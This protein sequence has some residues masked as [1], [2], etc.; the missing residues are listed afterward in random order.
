MKE[1]I[2]Y[3][4]NLINNKHIEDIINILKDEY[5]AKVKYNNNLFIVSYDHIRTSFN[6]K[7]SIA[8][9]GTIFELDNN[10][11]F[12]GKIVCL[13]FYKFFNYGESN[14]Y[15]GDYNNIYSIYEKIDG[16]LIK[17]YYYNNKWCIGS[18]NMLN[19]YDCPID[20]KTL[21]DI[22]DIAIKKYNFNYN[23]LDKNKIYCLELV[24][25]ENRIVLKYNNYELYHLMTRC[26]IT[27]DEYED[28]IGIPKPINY[29]YKNLDDVILSLK[30]IE[31]K[32]GYVIK[33]KC[34][35]RVKIKSEWYILNHHM[36][37]RENRL[38]G[39][40]I[41]KYILNDIVDD[42]I[43]RY[44]DIIPEVDKMKNKLIEFNNECNSIIITN[45]I[46][47]PVSIDKKIELFKS[48]IIKNINNLFIRKTISMIITNK[49][50]K[51]MEIFD[52]I[53]KYDI[54]IK[55]Y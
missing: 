32:E 43:G 27:L 47:I 6:K 28:D 24:S 49:I 11:I 7:G 35:N 51:P 39:K 13:P 36:G 45:N 22:F 26:M 42:I 14:S 23:N 5:E 50:S 52:I 33:Y 4:I 18:N 31:E 15:K 54:F 46:E 10:N 25:P 55:N 2:E 48:G 40:N 44:P 37:D 38:S 1:D 53:D 16:S 41:L 30:N 34:G 17:L 8:L 29:K 20:N 19:V 9:R 21:G 3:L 12:R